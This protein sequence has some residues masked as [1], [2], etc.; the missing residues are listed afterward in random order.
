MVRVG[1]RTATELDRS[2]DT[3]AA[4]EGVRRTNSSI[5]LTRKIER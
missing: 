5:L 1:C 4:I 3:I 2:I